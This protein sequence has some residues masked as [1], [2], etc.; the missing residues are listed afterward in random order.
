MLKLLYQPK[1]YE[2]CFLKVYFCNLIS[3]IFPELLRDDIFTAEEDEGNQ[4]FEDDEDSSN[5]SSDSSEE[6]SSSSEE[7]KV[8]MPSKAKR[9]RRQPISRVNQLDPMDPAAYS[10]I[11]RG[12]WSDGLRNNDED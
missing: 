4:S 8:E 10:N 6:E 3:I 12:K 11:P 9:Q 5:D 7:E 2:V 1:S